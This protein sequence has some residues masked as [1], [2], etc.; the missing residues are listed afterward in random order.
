MMCWDVLSEGRLEE[1][2]GLGVT[3]LGLEVTGEL[4]RLLLLSVS[5]FMA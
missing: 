3:G 4:L 1:R 2:R 5:E